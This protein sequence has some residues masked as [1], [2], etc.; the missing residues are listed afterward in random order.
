MAGTTLRIAVAVNFAPPS[1]G[2][3]GLVRFLPNS[4]GYA[5]WAAAQPGTAVRVS[6]AD[7]RGQLVWLV[8]Y[9][10]AQL[11]CS[12]EWYAISLPS[13]LT[14]ASD[15][16]FKALYALDVLQLDVALYG[17][18]VTPPRMA[19]MRFTADYTQYRHVLVAKRATLPRRDMTANVWL[20]LRPFSWD[21]WLLLFCLLLFDTGMYFMFERRTDAVATSPLHREL[22]RSA[23]HAASHSAFLATMSIVGTNN[24]VPTTVS[25][26]IHAFSAAFAK[27][28]IMATYLANMAS[29][30]T[31]RPQVQP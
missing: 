14:N 28:I 18:T 8:A 20:W 3:D 31:T 22:K 21:M 7:L 13:A 16:T 25:G 23:A 11:N 24:H 1:L 6:Q 29:Q 12:T 15:S 2:A 26:R 19:F 4:Q 30:L 9:V 5:A 17:A 10:A 27:W